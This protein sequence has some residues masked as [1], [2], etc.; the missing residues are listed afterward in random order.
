[1]KDQPTT[2]ESPAAAPLTQERP[3]DL[4][5]ERMIRGRYDGVDGR[6]VFSK[7]HDFTLVEQAQA[8]QVYPFFQALD[9]NDGPEA[10]IYGKRVLMFGSNNYLGLTRHPEVVEAAREAITKFGSSMTGSRLLNGSTHLHEELE[11]RIAEFLRKEAALVFTTGYLANLGTISSLVDKRAIAVVDKADHA[12]IYDGCKLA[13]GDMIRFRHNDPVRLDKVLK[14]VTQDRAALVVVDGVYSMGGDIVPLPELV[15]VCKRHG[16]RIF[17]DDAHAIGMIGEGGRGT[18]SHFG[19]E[20]DVDLVMGTFSK[21]LASIGGF[22][23]GPAKVISWVKHFARSLL[24]SASLPPASTAAA[25]ASLTVLQREPERVEQLRSLATQW[26]DGLR[27][28]GFNTGNSQTA[29]VPIYLGDEYAT[30]MFWKA[31][32]EEGVYTNPVIY[33]ATPMRE[34][35]LRTSCMATHT[36]GQIEQALEKFANVG[37][38]QGYIS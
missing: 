23:A 35:M 20:A 30:V 9:S 26:R 32:L 1:M 6:D 5:I 24:F 2:P 22:V 19:M 21:S 33:P 12:S 27:S 28:L 17:V 38:K 36:F 7:V 4:S 10:T 11:E 15:D 29:I 34:A 3:P 37:R 14:K 25:L 31:L 8:A 13:D 18:A 16:A